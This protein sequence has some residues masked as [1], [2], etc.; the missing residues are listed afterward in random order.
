MPGDVATGFTA[1]RDKSEK[2]AEVYTNIRKAVSAMEKDE[3][4]GMCPEQMAHLFY[5]MATKRNPAPRIVG[6]VTYAIFC[7]LNRILPTRFVNWLEG[8][9]Y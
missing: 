2:G 5:K 3:Q 7:F 8:V 6:G 1:A 4:N 9:M